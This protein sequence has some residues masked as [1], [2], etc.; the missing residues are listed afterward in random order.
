VQQY[1]AKAAA[2]KAVEALRVNI[3]T[4]TWMPSTLAELVTHYIEKEMPQKAYSTSHVYNFYLKGWIL[5]KWGKHPLA[6]IRTVGVE[7]WLGI[8]KLANGSK[9]KIRNL[10]SALFRHAM[11]HEWTGKNPISLVRQSGKRQRQ[12]EVL[13]VGEIRALLSKLESPFSTMVFVA[14]VTGLRVSELLALK[15]SDINFAAGEITLTRGVVRQHIG[16][17]KT[18]ASRKPIA[19]DAGLAE[20]LLNWRLRSAFNQS[21]DWIFASP[22]MNG[23]QP[24]WP[25]SLLR[26]HLRPAAK[27]AGITKTI[28][29]HTFRHSFATLLKANGE[30]VKVVQECLRHATSRVTLDV[31]TQAVTPAKRA[32]QSKVVAQ[33]AMCGEQLAPFG[34][35]QSNVDVVTA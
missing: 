35:T 22:E 14:A 32:A 15:W 12:P 17:M 33:L 16:D 21:A 9:S 23:A 4:E 2:Q 6:E 24:Y 26:R 7:E 13:E 5:P 28:G 3:N 29:W 25:E 19:M 27:Q 8:L 18:E 31:Y 1:P 20:M 34:P 30:D 11:R 10:M